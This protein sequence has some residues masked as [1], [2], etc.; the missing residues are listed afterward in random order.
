MIFSTIKHK[1]ETL[2]KPH[3]HWSAFFVDEIELCYE[4][5]NEAVEAAT[6]DK[7]G[8]PLIYT[9]EKFVS[10]S[11]KTRVIALH[12]VDAQTGDIQDL[13]YITGIILGH[14]IDDEDEVNM[15][16]VQLENGNVNSGYVLVRDL[17][18]KY[19]MFF[20]PVADRIETGRKFRM[21]Q[22]RFMAMKFKHIKL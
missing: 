6:K 18:Q 1:Y 15:K 19:K 14:L 5:L 10:G 17:E 22:A 11:D 13:S 7:D 4:R 3:K 9:Q 2:G 8:N 21:R 16:G 12:Y 20:A